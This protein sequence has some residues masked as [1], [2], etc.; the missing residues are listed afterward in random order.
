MKVGDL[1]KN[2]LPNPKDSWSS[3]EFGLG[4][5]IGIET[6]GDAEGAW[7]DWPG[8]GVY[9]SPLDQLEVVSKAAQ[10]LK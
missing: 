8:K 9:W 2:K 10:C 6:M 5:I 1:V 4:L 7:V 3:W